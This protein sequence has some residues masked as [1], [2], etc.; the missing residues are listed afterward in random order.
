MKQGRRFSAEQKLDVWRRWKAGQTLHEIGALLAKNIPPFV[1]WC[2]VTVGLLR[3]S[4]GVRS[5][6]SRCGSARKRKVCAEAANVFAVRIWISCFGH[7]NGFPAVIDPAPV[8]PT[9]A[10]GFSK[11][12]QVDVESVDAYHR[13]AP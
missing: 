4:G 8:N 2:R 3:P 7:T 13:T 11:R 10:V 9:V 12:A 6:R 1:V 5:S